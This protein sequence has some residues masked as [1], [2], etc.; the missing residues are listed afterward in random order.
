MTNGYND[1]HGESP[2]F[3]TVEPGEAATANEFADAS[4]ALLLCYPTPGET[5]ALD[6]LSTFRGDVVIHVG[7]WGGLT[8]T[9]QVR[10]RPGC[11]AL[12]LVYHLRRPL[13]FIPFSSPA[14]R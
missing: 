8:G 4:R 14:P 11:Q 6:A 7:E 2:A 12:V 9:V 5:M 1:Y 13:S 3:T 10:S